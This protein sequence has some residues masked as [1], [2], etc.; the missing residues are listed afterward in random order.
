MPP[1]LEGERDQQ[2]HLA[3]RTA[4]LV[5]DAEKRGAYLQQI[6][7]GLDGQHID[8]TVEEAGCLFAVRGA[9]LVEADLAEAGQLVPGPIEPATKRGRS[10]L[11]NALATTRASSAA[12]RLSA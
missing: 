10:V 12:R 5:A 3:A 1:R 2:R 4:K 11:E 9:K 7:A 8:P 6:L